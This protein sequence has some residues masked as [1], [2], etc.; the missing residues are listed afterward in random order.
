[1]GFIPGGRD[2]ILL[3]SSLLDCGHPVRYH[4]YV[5]DGTGSG[6]G[7]DAPKG[8]R[9]AIPETARFLDDDR[10]TYGVGPSF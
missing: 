1:M 3:D 4:L 10:G 8:R 5:A 7:L 6:I 9:V 2:G